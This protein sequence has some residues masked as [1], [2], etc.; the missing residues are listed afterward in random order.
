M[1]IHAYTGLP[2]SGKSYN[3]VEH[4]V[5]PALQEGRV[6]VT[7]LPLHAEVVSEAIPGAQLRHVEI[8][9]VRDNPGLIDEVFPAGCVCVLDELWRLWPAGQ[10]VNNIPEEFKS[11]LAEHRHRVDSEGR[12]TQ[13][14]FVT[15]D[16]AQVAAFARQLVEKTYIHTKLGHLG[17]SGKFKVAIAHGCVTGTVI[18][19]ARQLVTRLGT[20]K[21]EVWK[22][23]KSHTMSK[24][25][26][27]GADESSVDG[28]GN[29]WK[30][31]GLWAMFVLG[32]AC[33]GFGGTW[34]YRAFQDPAA[35]VGGSV[36]ARDQPQPQSGLSSRVAGVAGAP[37]VIPA[38][39]RVGGWLIAETAAESRALITDGTSGVWV[40]FS[41][42]CRVERTEAVVCVYNG[43]TY[44]SAAV[45]L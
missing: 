11:F 27:D 22:F 17:M 12:S 16:L 32:I 43:R 38:H 37:A 1:S 33:L 36:A 28:R 24:A 7:N 19:E 30:R 40:P 9:R 20:Y 41:T 21:P 18:P 3:V 13:I 42:Y 4:V 2:G 15:Q 29:I 10:K 34:A 14:V 23:Y 6:V 8:E 26:N 44:T 35:A 25:A 5:L 39:W 45:T 31:P